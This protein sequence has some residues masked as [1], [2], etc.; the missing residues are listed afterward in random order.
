MHL[1]QLTSFAT[2]KEMHELREDYAL[3]K[4][5]LANHDKIINTLLQQMNNLVVSRAVGLSWSAQNPLASISGIV[6]NSCPLEDET[7]PYFDTI[8]TS[9]GKLN[10]LFYICPTSLKID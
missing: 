5:Q 8:N 4:D 9:V 6:N 3:A 7:L 10:L 2:L 1:N